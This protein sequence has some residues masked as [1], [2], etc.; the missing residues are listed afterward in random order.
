MGREEKE[1]GAENDWWGPPFFINLCV[2]LTCGSHEVFFVE[3]P[4]KRHVNA[5]SDED[6]V[7][8]AT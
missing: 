3:L 6:Q 8:L 5:I 4:R 2:K 1:R 7:K